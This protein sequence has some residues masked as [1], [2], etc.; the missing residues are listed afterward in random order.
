MKFPGGYMRFQGL[1]A[2]LMVAVVTAGCTPM[3]VKPLPTATA[4]A[5]AKVVVYREGGFN[6][7]GISMIFGIDGLDQLSLPNGGHSQLYLRPGEHEV[8]VRSDQADRPFRLKTSI[9]HNEIK[10]FRAYANP[11]NYGK[12][13]LGN[14]AYWLG[15]AFKVREVVC[16]DDKDMKTLANASGQQQATSDQTE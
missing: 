16:G 13:F 15:N 9:A 10:C 8:F 3:Q 12:A 4:D 2:L 7:G 1:A 11:A 14:I 5:R 6:A